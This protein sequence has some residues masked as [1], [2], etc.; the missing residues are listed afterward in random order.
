VVFAE[1]IVGSLVSTRRASK[2]R[3]LVF[4]GLLVLVSTSRALIR[5]ASITGASIIGASIIGASIRRAL[6]LARKRLNSLLLV[7]SG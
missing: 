7:N 5:R 1:G 3:E 2:V 4:R 6:N